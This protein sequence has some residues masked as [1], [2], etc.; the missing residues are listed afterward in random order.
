MVGF[1]EKYDLHRYYVQKCHENGFLPTFSIITADV[2]I[3]R[4]LVLEN[5]SVSFAF[6]RLPQG[7]TPFPI[8]G[9]GAA[10]ESWRNG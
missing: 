4:N 10:A 1:G 2:N 9:Q 5:R 3:S 6:P 7:H 8:Q